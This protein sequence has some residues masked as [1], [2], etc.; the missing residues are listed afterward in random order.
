MKNKNYVELKMIR[1][2]EVNMKITIVV[3][4]YNGEKTISRCVDSILQQNYREFEIILVNDGSQ[5]STLEICHKLESKDKRIIVVNQINQGSFMARNAGILK[6]QG[7]YITFLDADDIFCR[8]DVLKTISETAMRENADVVQF[9]HY[10]SYFY[11][12]IKRKK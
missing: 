1:K 2:I 9:S 3:P 6:A 7:E 4:V 11:G 10:H 8:N 12:L 5:D